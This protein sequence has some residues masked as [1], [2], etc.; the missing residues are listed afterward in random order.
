MNAHLVG[1]SNLFRQDL[2]LIVRL[3]GRAF[4][5]L[6]IARRQAITILV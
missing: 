1:T 3:L 6:I 4:Q 5:E 2:L